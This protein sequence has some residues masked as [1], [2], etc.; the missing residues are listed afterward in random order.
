MNKRDGFE[1]LVDYLA[2]FGIDIYT[3]VT[4]V[5]LFIM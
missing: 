3:G 1:T 4:G 5:A 2:A